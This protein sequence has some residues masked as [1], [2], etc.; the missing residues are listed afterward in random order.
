MLPHAVL[1]TVSVSRCQRRVPTVANTQ[2]RRNTLPWRCVPDGT[3]RQFTLRKRGCYTIISA[4]CKVLIDI[5]SISNS[6]G[7][8]SISFDIAVNSSSGTSSTGSTGKV[9][10]SRADIVQ[11]F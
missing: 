11:R 6:S 9:A 4:G 2:R 8:G 5:S 7:G 3:L 10:H 1:W